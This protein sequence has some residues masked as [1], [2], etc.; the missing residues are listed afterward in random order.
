MSIVTTQ[1]Q[2][3]QSKTWVWLYKQK[4]PTTTPDVITFSS[5]FALFRGRKCKAK[6]T[7]VNQKKR[8]VIVKTTTQP[9]LN[10]TKLNN[11]Q[12]N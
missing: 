2:A 4:I 1:S 5:N 12:I 11:Q 6:Q 3:K 9:Q 8:K 7:E 10:Q